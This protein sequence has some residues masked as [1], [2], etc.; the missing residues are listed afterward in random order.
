MEEGS[1]FFVFFHFIII[2]LEILQNAKI[3]VMLIFIPKKKSYVD[4]HLMRS[5]FREI[6]VLHTIILF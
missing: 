5:L 6:D 3:K 4:L 2:I 1:V